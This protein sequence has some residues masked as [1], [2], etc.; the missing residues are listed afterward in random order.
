MVCPSCKNAVQGQPPFCP[1][2]SGTLLKG[3][4]N[5]NPA[6]TPLELTAWA[7]YVVTVMTAFLWPA[8]TAASKPAPSS[9]R[10]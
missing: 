7:T 2:C 3:P 10:A 4:F 9:V 8:R 5:W 1:S 6:P